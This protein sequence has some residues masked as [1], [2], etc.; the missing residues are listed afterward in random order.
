MFGAL[1]IFQRLILS[2]GTLLAI[3][4]GLGL[5]ANRDI[6][7]TWQ[8]ARK[9]YDHPFTVATSLAEFRHDG[10]RLH[11]LTRDIIDGRSAVDRGAVAALRREAE[12]NAARAAERYLGPK[13]DLPAQR[14]AALRHLLGRTE[15]A[16]GGAA[17]LLRGLADAGDVGGDL[18]GAVRRLPED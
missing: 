12:A 1:G 6:E 17:G 15:H 18:L 5:F 10:M 2:F 7:S 8:I 4:A 16:A 9:L 3:T 14:L 13:Q 11:V